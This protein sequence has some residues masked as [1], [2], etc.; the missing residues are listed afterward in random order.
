MASKT[1]AVCSHCLRGQHDTC[2]VP[3]TCGCPE[4]NPPAVTWQDPPPKR[5]GTHKRVLTDEQEA[6]LRADPKR[7]AL[8]RQYDKAGSATST[9]Y[10]IKKGKS[11]LVAAEW[12][13][14][15]RRNDRG[16]ALYVRYLGPGGSA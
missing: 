15:A 1:A 14:T 8:I 9:A 4:C 2:T 11:S 16:S 7:W 5:L 6:A 13:A 10:T 12:E 3:D